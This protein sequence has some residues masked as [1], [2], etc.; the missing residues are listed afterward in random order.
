M[1][2]DEVDLREA[3]PRKAERIGQRPANVADLSLVAQTIQDQ[4]RRRMLREREAD[5]PP[6]IGLRVPA[7]DHARHLV[8]LNA[9]DG[10][11]ALDGERREA[12]PVLDPAKALF[13]ERSHQLSVPQQDSRHITVVGVDAEEVHRLYFAHAS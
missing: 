5:L 1:V 7:D 11:A 9:G 4:T 12:G 2:L 6:E 3:V 8:T 10:Q 13:L